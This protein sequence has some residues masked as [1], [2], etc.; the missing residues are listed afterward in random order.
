MSAEQPIAI[1][2]KS[3]PVPGRWRWSQRWCEVFFAH[4][5][6]PVGQ[7]QP[8][9][10]AGLELD[11]WGRDAWLSAVAFR[12][13]NVRLRGL[14]P[15]GPFSNFLELNL[16]T[17]VRLGGG[18]AIYFLSIHAGS[19]LA[20]RLARWLTPLPYAHARIEYQR[21]GN[22]WR[23]DSYLAADRV[24][25]LFRAEFQEPGRAAPAADGS[26]DQ[27]LLERYTAYL[28]D[29]PGRLHRMVVL[30]APWQ[31]F[32]VDAEVCA[33]G[34]AASQRLDLTG[35]P[36]CCHFSPPLQALLWPTEVVR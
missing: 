1:R 11:T 3:G 14:P 23:F 15:L 24:R 4:W 29:R 20:V 17:Y 31:A 30:H 35:P 16:R 27:W 7:L 12:L 26:L 28:S 8:L 36:E 13:Q 22:A 18:S 2:E 21:R 33:R 6:L 34:L 10:P 5:R 25:P 9:V 19:R 32:L